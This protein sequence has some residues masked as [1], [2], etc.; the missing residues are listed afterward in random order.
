MFQDKYEIKEILPL[1]S[2]TI[3]IVITGDKTDERSGALKSQL[4]PYAG[5]YL[6]LAT[7]KTYDRLKYII[8]DTKSSLPIVRE[9]SLLTGMRSTLKSLGIDQKNV[10]IDITGMNHVI[11]F[12][13]IR[14]LLTEITPKLLFASYT[15]P[16]AYLKSSNEAFSFT[17]SEEFTRLNSIP[18]FAKRDRGREQVLVAML[19]FEG[20]RLLTLLEE[21]QPA[22]KKIV[23][24]VGFPSYS[25][26]WKSVAILSNSRALKDYDCFGEIVTCEAASPYKAY[27]LLSHLSKQNEG[28]ELLIAPLGTR[29]HALGAAIYAS[30]NSNCNLRFDFPVEKAHRSVGVLKTNIYHLSRFITEAYDSR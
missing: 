19:G 5:K 27:K 9:V 2:E 4:L 10:L 23:P 21:I 16:E 20:Y 18:G 6:T 25:P 15:E 11:L 3:D 8:N 28:D 24:V 22:P 1:L 7:E 13:L 14:I 12:F 17:L 26:G 29:P 30:I